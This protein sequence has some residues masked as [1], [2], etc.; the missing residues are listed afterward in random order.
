M[1]RIKITSVI[2]SV[3]MLCSMLMPSIEVM[4]DETSAPSE[5]QTTESK[6]E[7]EP[8]GVSSHA[9][10]CSMQRTEIGERDEFRGCTK[11]HPGRL[12]GIWGTA[13]K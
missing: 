7:K 4:A 3:A 5:T 12:R 11:D 9:P 1:K 6:D 13:A 10:F 2:L 8:E